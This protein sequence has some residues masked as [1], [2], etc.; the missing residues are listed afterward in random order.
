MPSKYIGRLVEVGIIKEV[1]R[2]TLTPATNGLKKQNVTIQD[3]AEV[4]INEMSLGRIEDANSG[5]VV[6]TY[7]EGEISGLI[8]D[9]TIGC[10]LYN[11]LGTLSSA[12]KSAPNALAYDH[13]FTVANTN[14]HQALS[15]E[16][17]DPNSQNGY[18]LAMLE[19]L[20]IKGEVGGY[21]E[22]SAT[23]KSKS[24]ATSTATIAYVAENNF[25]AKHIVVKMASAASGLAVASAIP[26]K[27]FSIKFSQNLEPFFAFGSTAPAEIYNKQLTAEISIVLANDA[28]TYK[29]YQL[30]G[31]MMAMLV[32]ITNTDVT[33][34]TSANPELKFTFNQIVFN[35]WK[36]ENGNN[37]IALE[38]LT[39]K[40]TYKLSETKAVEAVLSNLTASY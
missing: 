32:D 24:G 23:F 35:E 5:L 27:S 21:V 13:T 39:G 37:D 30:A 31:T 38:T 11:M 26:C 10:L 4:A 7:A 33:I 28:N 15:I 29:A 1:T 14:V 20:E 2:G 40:M 17:K 6:K 18:A 22:Y 16:I 34:A 36:I 3:V 25:I 12:A 8:T 19:T 9:K